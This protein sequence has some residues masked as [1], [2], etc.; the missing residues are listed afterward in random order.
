[1]PWAHL[2][3]SLPGMIAESRRG[4]TCL[5]G[6]WIIFTSWTAR[7]NSELHLSGVFRARAEGG[8][9]IDQAGKCPGP[10]IASNIRTGLVSCGPSKRVGDIQGLSAR[11]AQRG[12]GLRRRVFRDR[13][14]L[15]PG[16][17]ITR[18]RPATWT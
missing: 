6:I 17:G 9:S 14:A 4:A 1:M 10:E 12:A 18:L 5:A 8:D 2:G 11:T 3:S 13:G 16:S 7:N 15:L